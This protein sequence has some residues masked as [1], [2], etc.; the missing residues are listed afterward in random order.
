MALVTEEMRSSNHG[1]L[2]TPNL[3]QVLP[4]TSRGEGINFLPPVSAEENEVCR[5]AAS[6]RRK[7]I[8]RERIE[9]LLILADSFIWEDL[10][11]NNHVTENASMTTWIPRMRS[12]A[13]R[14]LTFGICFHMVYIN[15][16]IIISNQ[17]MLPFDAW[18]PYDWSKSPIFE[19]TNILQISGVILGFGTTLAACPAFYATFALIACSQCEKMRILLWN[20]K[21]KLSLSMDHVAVNRQEQF[22][23]PEDMFIL[24]QEELNECIKLHQ[25]LIRYTNE[26]ENTFSTFFVGIF[27][28]ILVE[29][30]LCAFSI[31]L[32]WGSPMNMMQS[33]LT[34]IFHVTFIFMFCWFASELTDQALRIRDA[35]WD[36]DWVGTPVSFQRS[37]AVMIS[38]ANQEIVMTAGKFL[39]VSKQTMVNILQ[40]SVSLFMFLLQVKDQEQK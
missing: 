8:R 20:I 26:M 2:L 23:T 16:R 32:R 34:Y 19:L 24:M 12:S 39:P 18:Y 38:C 17:R 27:L 25:K 30:C 33:V 31:V 6:L 15:A 14:F 21:Q 22:E 3:V 4:N 13:V 1:L 36:C 40:E 35:V 5:S 9:R 28:L 10:P 7:P 29:L 37:L 11:K